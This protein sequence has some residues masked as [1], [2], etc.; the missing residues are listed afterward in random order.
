[1]YFEVVVFLFIRDILTFN[2]VVKLPKIIYLKIM[3]KLSHLMF[4]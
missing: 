3:S 2:T 4:S 1:M